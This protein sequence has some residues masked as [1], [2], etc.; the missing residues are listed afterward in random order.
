MKT[1]LLITA[2]ATGFI[3]GQIVTVSASGQTSVLHG[4]VTGAV[5]DED[6]EGDCVGQI[7]IELTDGDETAE[8][9][10]PVSLLPD[11]LKEGDPLKIEVSLDESM[12]VE[13]NR[14]MEIRAAKKKKAEQ[15]Q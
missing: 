9:S 14:R 11:K 6:C 7:T 3:L 4:F 5:V 10:L 2:L 1:L 12:R 15:D 13:A 8:V